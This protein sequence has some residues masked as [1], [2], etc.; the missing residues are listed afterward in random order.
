MDLHLLLSRPRD[1]PNLSRRVVLLPSETD[2][3][4]HQPSLITVF[5]VRVV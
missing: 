3:H 5:A 2:Q 4:G 1:S